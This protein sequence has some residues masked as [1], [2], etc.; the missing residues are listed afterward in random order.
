MFW[1]HFFLQTKG[2]SLSTETFVRGVLCLEFS[3][4]NVRPNHVGYNDPDL[5]TMSRRPGTI[6]AGLDDTG[7]AEH[8]D[9]VGSSIHE[10]QEIQT[11]SAPIAVAAT[12]N[13]IATNRPTATH[14]VVHRGL[15]RFSDHF[16]IL[17]IGVGF[18]ISLNSTSRR[19]PQRGNLSYRSP[20]FSGFRASLGVSCWKE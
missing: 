4:A 14:H 20:M 10:H 11:C 19:S 1:T 5:S 8:P 7:L 6:P 9:T 3:L 15:L 2:P 16:S 18:S 12:P 17:V 13:K